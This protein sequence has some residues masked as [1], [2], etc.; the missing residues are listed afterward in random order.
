[1]H[2]GELSG[3]AELELVA[4]IDRVPHTVT[5]SAGFLRS[6]LEDVGGLRDVARRLDTA[7]D[8]DATPA[9]D[10]SAI[11][12]VD[13]TEQSE[14]GSISTVVTEAVRGG[15][16][17]VLWARTSALPTLEPL[18]V[19]A[20]SVDF[21]EQISV[22]GAV[23]VP[24]DVT[25]LPV[26][27]DVGPTRR[28]GDG[29]VIA[30]VNVSAERSGTAE[31]LARVEGGSERLHLATA[32]HELRRANATLGK[33]QRGKR[34]AAPAL[35]IRRAEKRITEEL[36]ERQRHEK[37]QRDEWVAGLQAEVEELRRRVAN[38]WPRRGWRLARRLAGARPR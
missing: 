24:S 8:P 12:L 25:L 29:V 11:L 28:E 1:M 23:L 6:R 14:P 26:E 27:V 17:V 36:E 5:A 2:V 38:T 18:L 32:L 15:R 30:C 35:F 31:R 7:D 9:A 33:E 21:F 37:E 16:Q 4:W 10:Q 20:G 13:L 19:G 22:E 3:D 34:L